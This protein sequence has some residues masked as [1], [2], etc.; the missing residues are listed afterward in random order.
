MRVWTQ[1]AVVYAAP[2]DLVP[3]APWPPTPLT[4]RLKPLG[5][6]PLTLPLL[7]LRLPGRQPPQLRI[8]QLRIQG[9]PQAA[10]LQRLGRLGD[11]LEVWGCRE[12]V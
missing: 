3:Q 10:V 7:L 6:P 11:C 1:H 5:H 4:W 8:L 12:E 2:A 9:S